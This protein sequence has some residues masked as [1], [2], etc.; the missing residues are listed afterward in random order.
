MAPKARFRSIAKDDLIWEKL[1]NDI[2]AWDKSIRS[3][4]IYR[5]VG[6]FIL[7]YRSG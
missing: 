3:S 7:Q 1:D 5:A 4:E 2:E 6:N